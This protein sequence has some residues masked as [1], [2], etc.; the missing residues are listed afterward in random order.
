M[1]LGLF[2]KKSTKSFIIKETNGEQMD[3]DSIAKIKKQ[4][5]MDFY[6]VLISMKELWYFLMESMESKQTLQINLGLLWHP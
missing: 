4:W 3:R 1:S 6:T 5:E 2:G